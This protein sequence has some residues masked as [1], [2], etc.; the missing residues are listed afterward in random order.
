MSRQPAVHTV[1][2]GDSWGDLRAGSDKVRE[3]YTTKK[4]VLQAKHVFT[5]PR[6]LM[7]FGE[8]RVLEVPQM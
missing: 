1:R 4:E 3:V 7:A 6:L 5:R 8:I 2:R